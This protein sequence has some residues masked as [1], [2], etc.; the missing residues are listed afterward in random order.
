MT[1]TERMRKGEIPR[2]L[3]K[4]ALPQNRTHICLCGRIG[5]IKEKTGSSSYV[6]QRCYDIESWMYELHTTA[7]G[8]NRVNIR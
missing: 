2:R 7:R 6:C 4:L 8:R 3:I 5:T 1:T